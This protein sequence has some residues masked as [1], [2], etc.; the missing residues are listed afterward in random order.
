MAHALAS[1]CCHAGDETH[2]RLFHVG[3]APA[4]GIGFVWPANLTNHDHGVGFGVLIEQA[5]DVNMLEAVDRVSAGAYRAGLAQA[6]FGQ[7]G[8]SLVGQGAGAA[9]HTNAALAVDVAGHDAN[10]DLVG[11]D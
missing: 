9:D 6:D 8:Y 7:L 2:N 5:H 3:F 1:R 4:R 10:F 11:R